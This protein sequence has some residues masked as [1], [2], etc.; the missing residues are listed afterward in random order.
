MLDQRVQMIGLAIAPNTRRAWS[1]SQSSASASST[2]RRYLV[3][4]TKWFG[5]R[6]AEPRLRA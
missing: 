1:R 3:T 6:F 4:Y 5:T 2:L